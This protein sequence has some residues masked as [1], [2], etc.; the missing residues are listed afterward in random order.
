M[1][2]YKKHFLKML[3]LS[4]A[5]IEEYLRVA[6]LLKAMKKADIWAIGLK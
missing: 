6:A 2:L 1:S 4:A 5:D 3:D